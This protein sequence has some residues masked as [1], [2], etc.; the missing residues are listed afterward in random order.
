MINT[1][2]EMN[3]AT[4]WNL[5]IDVISGRLVWSSDFLKETPFPFKNR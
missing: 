5:K 3:I 1:S 4:V 2:N